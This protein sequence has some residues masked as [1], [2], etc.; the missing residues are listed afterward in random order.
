M[1]KTTL[2]YQEIGPT[3]ASA[4]VFLHGF[5]GQASSFLPLMEGLSDSFRCISFD[6]PGH[7]ASLFSSSLRLQHLGGLED[8]AAL[9]LED[10]ARLDIRRFSLF[11]YSMGGRVAQHVAL[12]SPGSIHKLFLES[13][14][15]GIADLSERKNR[16]IR[17]RA[18]LANIHSPEDFRKFLQNWY[19]QPLFQTLSET[20]HLPGLILEK[21]H[22]PVEEYRR[23]LNLLGVGHQAFLAGRLSEANVSIHY[24]CGEQ[25]KA[26]HQ[27]GLDIQAWIPG[28]TLEVFKNASHNIHIQY[29]QEILR[30]IWKYLI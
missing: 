28:I 22:H 12:V 24:F 17:D 8:T 7:G 26:Y 14:S 5:M 4:V 13:A 1:N 3:N 27:A 25:D 9:L 23:A 6:L 15:F 19:R 20:D 11:G 10:L 29:P 2:S 30:T 16:R 18:L 21:I